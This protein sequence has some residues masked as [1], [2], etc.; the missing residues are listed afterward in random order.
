MKSYLDKLR[1]M[2]PEEMAECRRTLAGTITAPSPL[3]AYFEGQRNRARPRNSAGVATMA[4][5]MQRTRDERDFGGAV[6]DDA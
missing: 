2:T 5:L 4:R 1:D 3:W 6:D